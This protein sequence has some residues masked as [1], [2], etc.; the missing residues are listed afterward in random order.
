MNWEVPTM[1]SR[2]SC[3]NGG[4]C[5]S[6]LRRF[7]PLWAGYFVLLL[8]LLPVQLSTSSTWEFGITAGL[9]RMVLVSGSAFPFGGRPCFSAAISRAFSRCSR[10]RR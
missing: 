5:R 8:F 7:W 9:Q 10:R 2:T 3:F 1:K 6:L 4:V